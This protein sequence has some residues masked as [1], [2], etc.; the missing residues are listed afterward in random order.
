M[1]RPQVSTAVWAPATA[2]ARGSAHISYTLYIVHMPFLIFLRAFLTQGPQWGMGPATA[3]GAVA[4]FAATLA[5]A[6]AIWYGFEGRTARVRAA[7]GQRFLAFRA[8]VM[9][10]V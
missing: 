4:A 3:L 1:N 8:L 9:P 10:G 2:F 5:Y 7:V 6:A